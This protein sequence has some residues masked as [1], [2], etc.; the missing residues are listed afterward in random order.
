M[1]WTAFQ[2]GAERLFRRRERPRGPDRLG[3]T[4]Y[5]FRERLPAGPGRHLA[6]AG[7][8][9]EEYS[10]ARE[11][12]AGV[13]SCPLAGAGPLGARALAAAAVVVAVAG[14][15]AGLLLTSGGDG[16]ELAAV[17][18]AQ[19]GGG[20]G[21]AASA[22]GATHG[23]HPALSPLLL[24]CRSGAAVRQERRGRAGAATSGAGAL[25]ARDADG[26]GEERL[27]VRWLVAGWPVTRRRGGVP[28]LPA[29][30][31]EG[32]GLRASV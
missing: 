15:T 1:A 7:S 22:G 12:D 16:R 17:A 26:R 11:G 4:A 2:T 13:A 3:G 24:P 31:R 21:A 27:T 23:A 18:A 8:P 9:H 5:L 32:G 25:A 29:M 20:A 28:P 14:V 10:P 6:E 19:S 30:L